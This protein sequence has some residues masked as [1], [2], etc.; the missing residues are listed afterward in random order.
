MFTILQDA[1]KP[2]NKGNSFVT[3]L[4]TNQTHIVMAIKYL[5]EQVEDMVE[6][7]K[8]ENT[9]EVKN[10]IESQVMIFF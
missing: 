3:S 2:Q 7:T 8:C 6:K 1:S 4:K 9:N 10:I 5:N